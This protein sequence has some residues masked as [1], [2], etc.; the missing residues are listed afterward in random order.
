[1]TLGKCGAPALHNTRILQSPAACPSRDLEVFLYG[2]PRVIQSQTWVFAGLSL[3]IASVASFFASAVR[4][5][6]SAGV[7]V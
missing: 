3:M 6:R 5:C 2:F 7:V 4:S 1:L